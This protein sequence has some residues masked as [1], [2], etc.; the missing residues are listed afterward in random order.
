M[1]KKATPE[2]IEV[3]RKAAATSLETCLEEVSHLKDCLTLLQTYMKNPYTTKEEY[4]EFVSSASLITQEINRLV[5]S[6][7]LCIMAAITD[8]PVISKVH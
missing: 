3:L 1:T 2:S 7:G 8:S 5:G 4:S 6:A